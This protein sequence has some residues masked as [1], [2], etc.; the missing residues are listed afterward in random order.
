MNHEQN[1]ALA[2]GLVDTMASMLRGADLSTPVPT[3]PGWDLGRLVVHLGGIHRWAA[4]L[5]EARPQERMAPVKGERGDDIVAWFAAGS[6]LMAGMASAPADA[7][8]WA[9]GTDQRVRFWS[10]RMVHETAIHLADAALALGR[11]PEIDAAIAVDGIDEFLENLP[12]ATF[13]ATVANIRGSDSIHLHGTD[14]DHAEWMI[15][16]TDDGFRWDHSHGKGTVAVRGTA[17][18][19]YLLVWGRCELDTGSF[20][21]F[22]DTGVMRFWLDNAKI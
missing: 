19:L 9:W 13:S 20:E 5:V 11:A 18:D 16:L 12:S 2:A 10:R 6:A 22:G 7:P 15:Q 14:T 1:C 17:L 21:C 3:C 4:Q 8:M